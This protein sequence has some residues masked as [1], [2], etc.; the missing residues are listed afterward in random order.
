MPP[1]NQLSRAK[2][3]DRHFFLVPADWEPFYKGHTA[4]AATSSS[5]SKIE[6]TIH[7]DSS[8]ISQTLL[9]KALRKG[10][11]LYNIVGHENSP[12]DKHMIITYQASI[13]KDPPQE[14]PTDQQENDKAEAFNRES[15]QSL[16]YLYEEDFNE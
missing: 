6:I 4:Q 16:D 3:D 15:E 12:D 7:A 14:R 2:Y 10:F 1:L 5:L 9:E 8:E 11:Q 13:K